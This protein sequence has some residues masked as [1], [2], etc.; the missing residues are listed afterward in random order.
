MVRKKVMVDI[1]ETLWQ[2]FKF[3]SALVKSKLYDATEEAF[4]DYIKKKIKEGVKLE[5]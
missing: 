5:P 4:R 3:T 2:K 1:D